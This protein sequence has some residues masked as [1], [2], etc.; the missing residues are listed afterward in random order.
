MNRKSVFGVHERLQWHVTETAVLR[1]VLDLAAELGAEEQRLAQLGLP[2]PDWSDRALIR[3]WTGLVEA[4][5]AADAL[6]VARRPLA[7]LHRR[8]VDEARWAEA[9]PAVQSMLGAVVDRDHERY[10]S[11][12][13]RLERL[14]EVRRLVARRDQLDARLHAE[15]PRLHAALVAEP[16]LPE[17]LAR[18]AHFTEAWAWA[19]AGTAIGNRSAIDV[20]AVQT[21]VTQIEKDIRSQVED[22][23]ATRALSHAVAGDR[24]TRTARA[25][26]QQYAQLVRRLGKGT[27]KYQAQRLA[28]VRQAM[29]RCRSAVPV[30]ILP[31]YRIADQLRI[32]ADMFDVVVVDEASQAGLEAT[33]LQYLAPRIVVIGDDKRVSP[34]AVG[35][36]QHQLRDLAAQYLY[37]DQ[38]RS[39]WQDPQRSLFDEAKMR[40][41][42]MLTLVE[43]RRCVPEII[44]FS[45]QI[46]YEPD[47]VRLVPVRQ[48][49]ADRLEPVKP[50]L[51][52]EGYQRGTTNKVNPVEADAIVEQLEKCCVDPRYDGLT[53]GVISL[54]GAAQAKLI[55]TR[56]LDRVSA[57][58]WK[59]RD[60]RCG[61]AAD[62][63]GSERDVTFL[64]M[65]AAPEVGRRQAALTRELYVQRY[66]VAASRAKDQMWLF[67]SIRPENLGNSEDMRF[68]LLDYCYRTERSSGLDD[69][70][71]S[72]TVPEQVRAEPFESLLEQRV[73]NRL[74]ERGFR[75]VPQLD[76]QGYRLDL[77][78]IGATSRL[79]IE[80]EG[81]TWHG[82]MAYRRDMSEQRELE[83]CGWNIVR[84][85]ESEF[86]FDH[87]RAL[88]PMWDELARLGIQ[89]LGRGQHVLS[90]DDSVDV[91]ARVPEVITDDG[92]PAGSPADDLVGTEPF[93]DDYV[94]VD[95]SADAE[96][97]LNDMETVVD[98]DPFLQVGEHLDPPTPLLRAAPYQG[99]P[100]YRPFR[101]S[102]LPVGGGVER[103]DLV[104]GLVA[105]V[106]VEGPILGHR[107]HSVYVRSSEGVRVGHQIAKV[108]NSAV[109]AAVRKGRLVQ[110]DPLRESGVRPGTFRLPDQPSVVVRE[111]GPRQF[112]HLPPA[113]LAAVMYGAADRVGW[114]DTEQVFRVTLGRY[115]L[116]RMGSN[117]RARLSAVEPLARHLRIDRGW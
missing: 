91:A 34:S 101:G 62:F 23:A 109:T 16:G 92:A 1:R 32:H 110:D 19:A 41:T 17:W 65:V 115:G 68:R 7:E 51:V 100:P 31:T 96:A 60:L 57:D 8:L 95:R 103:A 43:H 86:T 12:H 21:E 64:S 45:N 85:R 69:E 38:F 99:L 50:V 71:I 81:D 87:D 112:E 36:D 26:L 11:D 49:G 14:V 113:E 84:I 83:R 20:N 46:A 48:F 29:D 106:A 25:S 77:V 56:L 40:F 15:A 102:V 30:W 61:D 105:I 39:T 53:F 80:C 35:V 18:L 28:E 111:L 88:K 79:A 94:V 93:V 70:V 107:L 58:E 10:A 54:L 2:I 89:P 13:R 73:C 98:Q 74:V 90:E 67:H 63:Q 9:A 114:D 22:L 59:A 24:L 37:D 33:F 108:L 82:P 3:T 52:E 78:V 97:A 42:G 5:A 75:V 4:A 66:N 76:A 117:V 72:E 55:E 6:T 44:E 27:G 104:E 47:G 116:R